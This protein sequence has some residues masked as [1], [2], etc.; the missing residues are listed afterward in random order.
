MNHCILSLGK[1]NLEIRRFE[2]VCSQNVEK[3]SFKNNMNATI[4]STN[5]HFY[6]IY[7]SS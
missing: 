2:S 7:Y 5:K 1:G 4:Q 3:I 6:E